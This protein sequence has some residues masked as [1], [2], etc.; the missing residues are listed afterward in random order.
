MKEHT[1]KPNVAAALLIVAVSLTTAGAAEAAR[2]RVVRTRPA[3]V[4]VTVRPG[5]PIRRTLPAVIVRPG[6]AVR[7]VP[8]AYLAPV[9]FGAALLSF[10]YQV[11]SSLVVGNPCV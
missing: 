10:M 8:R 3:R 1:V 4:R 5:F 11:Q 7:V 9:V 2:V 6:V